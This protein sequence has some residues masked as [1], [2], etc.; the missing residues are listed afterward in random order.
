MNNF[1]LINFKKLNI[2]FLSRLVFN[3]SQFRQKKT[4]MNSHKRQSSSGSF[5][6]DQMHLQ[7]SF[8]SLENFMFV[9][10]LMQDEIMVPSKLKDKV[11][12][13]IKLRLFQISF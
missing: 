12:G 5:N 4:I 3:Q 1:S 11:F 10:K 6:Q 2:V 7:T 13:K 9:S 8:S